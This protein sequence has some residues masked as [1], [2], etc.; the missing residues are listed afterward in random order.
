MTRISPSK[1]LLERLQ[2]MTGALGPGPQVDSAP[3]SKSSSIT[4]DPDTRP[5][6]MVRRLQASGVSNERILVTRLVEGMLAQD[7]GPAATGAQFQFVVEQVVQT[8][9]ADPEAW[10][11]CRACVAEALG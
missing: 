3:G 9:E 10:A 8:L 6:E 1:N 5:A 2:R 4:D 11:L 7:L